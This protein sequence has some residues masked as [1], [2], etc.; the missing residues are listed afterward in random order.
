MDMNMEDNLNPDDD[1]SDTISIMTSPS[2]TYD[3][4]QDLE[5]ILSEVGIGIR[6][7]TQ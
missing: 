1:T 6:M 3:I 4:N 5:E 7:K 2:I